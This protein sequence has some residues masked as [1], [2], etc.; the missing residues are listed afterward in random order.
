MVFRRLFAGMSDCAKAI[1]TEKKA[2]NRAVSR[3]MIVT[4]GWSAVRNSEAHHPIFGYCIWR[5]GKLEYRRE[6]GIKNGLDSLLNFENPLLT[7]A[8]TPHHIRPDFFSLCLAS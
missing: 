7:Q 1:V 8:T 5:W 3:N 2:R 6:G 4:E